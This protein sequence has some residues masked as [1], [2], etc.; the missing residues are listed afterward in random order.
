MIINFYFNLLQRPP[1][2]DINGQWSHDLFEDSNSNNR[3][4]V[5]TSSRRITPNPNGNNKLV[6]ENLFYEVT[7]EDLEVD[8]DFNC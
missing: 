4:S 3:R 5:A 7:Q 2:G 1:R 6:V 8:N